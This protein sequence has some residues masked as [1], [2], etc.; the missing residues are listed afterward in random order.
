MNYRQQLEPLDT[1]NQQLERHAHPAQWVNPKP[2]GRYNLVV[3]GGG[4]AG[5]VTAA[6]AAGLGAKVA[7]I[8][9]GLL[10]GD[11]L[12]V[13]CVP[14]KA[15]LAASRYAATVRQAGQFGTACE[16]ISVDFSAVMQ[17][18]RKL[19]AGISPHDS[20]QRFQQLGIDVYFGQATFVDSQTIQVATER[21]QFRN[22]VIATG[23][24]AAAP[25][26]PGL[27]TVAYL[28]NE[29]IFS[30]T[31]LP[32]RLV[33]I[34]GGPIGCEM[35]QAFARFGAQVTLLE[36]GSHVLSREDRDAAKVVQASLV[37]DG[38]E[39]L[40]GATILSVA[41]VDH[42]KRINIQIDSQQRS[43]ESDAILLAVGR[44]PNVDGL[45]LETIGI[46][47]D[48]RAG[49][50]VDDRLRTSVPHIFAAG[51]VCSKFKFTH[52][53][54]FMARIVIQNSLFWG[55]A[56]ASSLLIPWCTYTSPE[57]AH[58]GLTQTEA[59]QLGNEITTYTQRL[60]E[61]DRAILEGEE[62]GF[63]RVYCRRGRDQI[64]GATIVASHAGDMI[65]EITM[66]MKH[67][68]GL[69]KIAATIHPYPTQAEAIRKIGDQYNRSRLT[70]TIKSLFQ[71]WLA[72]NRSGSR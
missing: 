11:C 30:L 49:V 56:K 34:G 58:V 3:I 47:Y 24:R 7:L 37:R 2:D 33:V 57:L 21:L 38:I 20:A 19:R 69:K 71:K 53:A 63:V 45:G 16:N 29:T 12:N 6:G 8:E 64:L 50:Q 4:T 68:I 41:E 17:R 54:D 51:D 31:T 59:E 70:P 46:D 27:S 48:A 66:A 22:A 9:R 13:G 14:S 18:M 52:A 36:N 28:T 39:V 26:I 5:L 61:V 65:S 42:Q 1:W 10:G 15:I 43:L 67:R 55:R 32:K 40:C 25:S 35:A 23:G 60:S 44:V 72:W 62:E